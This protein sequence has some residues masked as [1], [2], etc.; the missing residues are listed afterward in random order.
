MFANP[1]HEARRLRDLSNSD[2]HRILTTTLLTS[3]TYINIPIDDVDYTFVKDSAFEVGAKVMRTTLL[4]PDNIEDHM[5]M[6]GYL[7][8]TIAF[9]EG[10]PV[11]IELQRIAFF[12]AVVVSEFQKLV[13]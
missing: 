12:V 8:P 2:K 5:D 1:L 6:K 3:T 13:Y 7:L 4:S 11:D 9:E 10:W